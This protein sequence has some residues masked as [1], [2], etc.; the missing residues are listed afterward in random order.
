MK[1]LIVGMGNVGVMHGWMLA[2][3]G[4]D[5]S[6]CRAQGNGRPICRRRQHGCP[7]SPEELRRLCLDVIE[8][9]EQLGVAMPALGS[10]KKKICGG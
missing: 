5:V 6:H 7:G 10:L 4:F 3:A 8:T 9:G 1:T 2:Q